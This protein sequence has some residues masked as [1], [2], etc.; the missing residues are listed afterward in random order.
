M[1]LR[2]VAMLALGGTLLGFMIS[3]VLP[4]RYVARASLAVQDTALISGA[5]DRALSPA[6]LTI[7]IAQDPGYV[8]ILNYTPM[9]EI[10]DQIRRDTVIAQQGP[11]TCAIRYTDDDRYTAVST[12]QALLNELRR[13]L[14]DA[15]VKQPVEVGISGP[16]AGLCAFE[17]ATAGLAAGLCLW[18]AAGRRF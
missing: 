1:V 3:L 10:V 14:G 15:K 4:R 6:F 17:G 8:P 11:K 2:A 9:D 16:S 7:F 5:A 12:A 18:F 13:D